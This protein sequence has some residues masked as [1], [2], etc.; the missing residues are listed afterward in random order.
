MVLIPLS[1][2][3]CVFAAGAVPLPSHLTSC[4]AT[5][6]NLYLDS[7]FQTVI[8]KPALYILHAFQVLNLTYIEEWRLLGYYAMW[9]L[10]VT[11]NV[12]PH[13]PIPVS[14]MA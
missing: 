8:R 13:S 11:A 1:V 9:L 12:V 14:H 6:S 7:S 10:L 3:K 5:K 4:T 2:E